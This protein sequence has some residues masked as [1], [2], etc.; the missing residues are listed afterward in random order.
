MTPTVSKESLRSEGVALLL[1]YSGFAHQNYIHRL[2]AVAAF[3]QKL[4][5]LLGS[6]E[7][8]AAF[9]IEVVAHEAVRQL[10]VSRRFKEA[11][12][13]TSTLPTLILSPAGPNLADDPKSAKALKELMRARTT[14]HNPPR[15]SPRGQPT[16][17]QSNLL[18]NGG[19][20]LV[21]PGVRIKI[22]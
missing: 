19:Y 12:I 4:P 2:N 20:L 9:F 18:G 7:E 1:S 10:T 3:L 5:S 21:A 13:L 17:P 14:Y 6:E 15:V 22:S 16:N 8:A 11:D